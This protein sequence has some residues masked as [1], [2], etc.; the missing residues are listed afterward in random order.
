[1]VWCIDGL[2]S[3]WPALQRSVDLGKQQAA[4]H[5]HEHASSQSPS[6]VIA[7]A[8]GTQMSKMGSLDVPI[9][10]LYRNPLESL[11][12]SWTGVYSTRHRTRRFEED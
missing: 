6:T 2:E 11:W 7:D 8:Q 4:E 12:W 1:M 10:S 3:L 5:E 9:V